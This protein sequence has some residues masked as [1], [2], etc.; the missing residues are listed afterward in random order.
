MW[1]EELSRLFSLTRKAEETKSTLDTKQSGPD[2]TLPVRFESQWTGEK[3]GAEPLGPVPLCFS[4]R[5]MSV[6]YHDNLF[7]S[8][9]DRPD[10][11]GL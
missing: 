11:G 4:H 9:R 3:E 5:P 1:L 10:I 7:A 8:D 2:G 6:V